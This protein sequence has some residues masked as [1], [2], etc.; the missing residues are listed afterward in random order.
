MNVYILRNGSE[1]YHGVALVVARDEQEAK[2]LTTWDYS[3]ETTV[4]RKLEEFNAD[5]I[6]RVEFQCYGD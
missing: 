5:G 3:D 1:N 6:P 4:I 2:T